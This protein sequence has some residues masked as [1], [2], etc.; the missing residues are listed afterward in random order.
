M[1]SNLLL[2]V[3]YGWGFGRGD[4]QVAL[5]GPEHDYSSCQWGISP[6]SF[7]L[8][9]G[10]PLPIFQEKLHMVTVRKVVC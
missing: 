9:Q 2:L 1:L 6:G 10:L 3:A 5:P 4:D 8:L 7:F